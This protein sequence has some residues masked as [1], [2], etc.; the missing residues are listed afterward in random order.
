[1]Q[2]DETTPHLKHFIGDID[3]ELLQGVV[4]EYLKAKDVQKTC[5]ADTRKKASE[6]AF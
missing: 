5:R 1:M 2:L 4:L 6:L 3:E